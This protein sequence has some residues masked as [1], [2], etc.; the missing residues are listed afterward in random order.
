MFSREPS[1]DLRMIASQTN[2]EMRA[3]ICTVLSAA[4]ERHLGPILEGSQGPGNSGQLDAVDAYNLSYLRNTA[5]WVKF[6]T[7][8]DFRDLAVT[9]LRVCVPAA[10]TPPAKSQPLVIYEVTAQAEQ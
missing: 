1:G 9:Q 3:F 8:N 7:W 4:N 2:W 5:A 10:K 6:L